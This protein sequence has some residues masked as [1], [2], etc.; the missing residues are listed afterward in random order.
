MQPIVST[1][2]I[3]RPPDEVFAFATDPTRFPEW[4]K[5]VVSVEMEGQGI[6]AQFTTTR[7]IGPAKQTI[8]Q[9]ITQSDPPRHWAARGIGGYILANGT[10]TVESLDEG[11]RSRVTFSLDFDARGPARAF[12]P[13]VRAMTRSAAPKS[14]RHLKELLERESAV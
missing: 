9:K 7:Q 10:I 1:I 4:Q 8:V 13:M 14:Y 5:D 12:L 2:E 6:G 3:A 11:R